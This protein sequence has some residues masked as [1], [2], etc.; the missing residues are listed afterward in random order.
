MS[1]AFA[2][3]PSRQDGIEN[4]DKVYRGMMLSSFITWGGGEWMVE[5]FGG[6]HLIYRGAKG[7]ISR[8]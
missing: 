6:N 8:N 7:G 3:M 4:S 2:C 5:D 1:H